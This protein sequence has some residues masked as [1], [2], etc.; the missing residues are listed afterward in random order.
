MVNIL[1]NPQRRPQLGRNGHD[2]SFRRTFSHSC[3]QLLPV[4]WDFLSP[5]ESIR[6]NDSLFTRTQPLAT[7]AFI[8]ATEHIYYFF[9]PMCQIDPYFDNAFYG[10]KDFVNTNDL[11]YSG[12]GT[13]KETP[14][15]SQSILLSNIKTGIFNNFLASVT[16]DGY[17]IHTDGNK[18]KFLCLAS[19]KG[20][21]D[22]TF[23]GATGL[24][25]FGIPTLW[26]VMR[27][28]DMLD[29]GV[30]LFYHICSNDPASSDNPQSCNFSI[31]VHR[32]QAYQKIWFDFFRN[33]SYSPNNPWAYNC[34]YAMKGSG[35]NGWSYDYS[36]LYNSNYNGLFKLRYHPL[37]KDFFTAIQPT[38]LFDVNDDVQGYNST[39][40]QG[41]L[42][43]YVLSAYGVQ[44]Q[45]TLNQD[46]FK[47]TNIGVTTVPNGAEYFSEN[48]SVGIVWPD[49]SST[50]VT[51][52]QQLRLMYAYDKL[53]QI[54]QRAGKH[55][56]DQTEA[57]FG[58]RPPK[59]MSGEVIYLGSHSSRLAI[60]EIAATAAGS[61]GSANVMEA[62][63]SLGELAGRAIGSSGRNRTIKYKTNCHGFLMAVYA[64]VPDIDYLS[65]GT[66]RRSLWRSIMD[67][68]RPEFDNLGMQPLYR[69]QLMNT[70]YSEYDSIVTAARADTII[71]WQYRWMEEKL[72]YDRVNGAFNY[73]L[74]NWSAATTPFYFGRDL[75][76]GFYCSPCFFDSVFAMTFNPYAPQ[77]VSGN[78]TYYIQLSSLP[79]G[80]SGEN[81]LECPIDPS[82]CYSRD[83]FLTSID[84]DYKKSSWLSPFSL[85]TL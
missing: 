53:L 18:N 83:N 43:S 35:T 15:V 38:P 24:D 2:P 44:L 9:V 31:D 49:K 26:N 36:T 13:N 29:Y 80:F 76:S 51:S 17:F 40:P 6:I 50:S 61:N 5:N 81:G 69:F 30:D 7:P 34:G 70:F 55:V 67:Y 12:R 60:G 3:G 11:D 62:T 84:F 52:L 75:A 33:S 45:G 79:S 82:I 25:E 22:N 59:G 10:I 57:H 56:D 42:N 16:G 63:S 64:L 4:M 54:T 85:P 14:I 23:Y 20:A 58:V 78:D 8:R 65:L 41:G 1:K 73:T 21:F 74:R 68:P 19:G 66:D 71:G 48:Q 28:L 32:I 39:P 27:L 46:V 47:N 72:S 37:K 77:L